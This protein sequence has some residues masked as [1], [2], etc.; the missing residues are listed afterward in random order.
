M[1]PVNEG[2]G[3]RESSVCV[4]T[5]Q[6]GTNDRGTIG[7]LRPNGQ[8]QAAANRIWLRVGYFWATK[9]NAHIKWAFTVS[10]CRYIFGCFGL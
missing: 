6:S 10:V 1:R 8:N 9:K 7:R 3:R 2:N 4:R 5:S